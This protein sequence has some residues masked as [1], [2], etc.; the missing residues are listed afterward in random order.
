MFDMPYDL[1]THA[2]SYEWEEVGALR[3]RFLVRLRALDLSHVDG[4]P[5]G[6]S[7]LLHPFDVPQP[8]QR[9]TLSPDAPDGPGRVLVQTG[10]G[11]YLRLHPRRT[12]WLTLLPEDRGALTVRHRDPE[13]PEA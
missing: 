13:R 2:E 1:I 8:V 5:Q 4:G 10:P 9:V 6:R 12:V 3:E 7:V 11:E